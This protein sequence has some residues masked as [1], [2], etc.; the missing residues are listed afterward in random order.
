M[1]KQF[2]VS[3]HVTMGRHVRYPSTIEE[4][5]AINRLPAPVLLQQSLSQLD[6]RILQI[7]TSVRHM[8]DIAGQIA[9]TLHGSTESA[10][11]RAPIVEK[12]R[13]GALDELF[14]RCAWVAEALVD[15]DYQL[16]R[17]QGVRRG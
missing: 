1:D 2:P 16:E 10:E 14:A 15:L 5:E 3:A 13:G 4:Q 12:Q 7:G 17:V 11:T 9:D 6:E 8:A